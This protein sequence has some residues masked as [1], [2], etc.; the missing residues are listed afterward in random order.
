MSTEALVVL[1]GG[2]DSTT[3]MQWALENFGR[4]HAVTFRYGQR[5]A[6]EVR[7]AIAVAR[8]LGVASHKILELDLFQQLGGNALVD[9]SQEIS[10]AEGE[11]PTTFVPGRNVL[12]LTAAAAHAYNLGISDLVT[13]VCQT[14]YSGY[15]D[16]RRDTIQALEMTLRFALDLTALKIHTPLMDWSKAETVKWMWERGPDVYHA[17]QLTHTCY[18]GK[19]PPCGECPACRLRAKGFEGANYRDPL[20]DTAPF[21]VKLSSN[22]PLQREITPMQRPDLH[23]N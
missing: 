20:L 9:P 7:S 13:G 3:C 2:Q 17:L 14:D 16:C 18:E 4:V 21:E 22:D 5:H 8:Y 11:L 6:R 23:F 19:Y 1:S 12:F 15:P 10:Q